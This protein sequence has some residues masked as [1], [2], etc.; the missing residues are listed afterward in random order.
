MLDTFLIIAWKN[1]TRRIKTTG[2]LFFCV[3]ISVFAGVLVWVSYDTVRNGVEL[4]ESRMSA[5]VMV[6]PYETE[7]SDASMLYSGI[8]QSV[9]M[10]EDIVEQ[11]SN[12][13]VER[14]ESQF[15]LQTLPTAGCCT[16]SLEL[17]LVGVDW[18]HDNALQSYLTDG[19]KKNM[20]D[21]DILIGSNVEL[22]EES[23]II[24]NTPF[25]IAG[26]LE[27]TGT[28]LDDSVIVPID[29]LKELARINFPDNYFGNRNPEELVTCVL[30]KLNDDVNPQEYLESVSDVEARKVL[31]S[32]TADVVKGEIT[33]LFRLLTGAAVIILILCVVAMY[34]QVQAM[35]QNR[36][37]EIG[38]LRSLGARRGDIYLMFLFEIGII[39]GSA[40]VL[41]SFTA[42]AAADQILN[43]V[44]QYISFPV[45]GWSAG[46]VLIHIFGGI[47]AVLLISFLSTVLPLRQMLRMSPQD[48]IVQGEL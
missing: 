2:I 14:V 1:L 5:D 22:E 33:V 20:G 34:S 25:R 28:Y 4:S 37:Q 9:Y 48:A 10:D 30:I 24:L 26:V 46:F 19:E 3:G 32:S 21:E 7:L 8:A 41:A 12:E 27:A 35:I 43:W 15:Y 11:L 6:Y 16:T 17:R 38:Y 18:E 36:R 45:S 39:V 13:Y 40:S 42:V 31:V 23:T 44:R 47:V 29:R